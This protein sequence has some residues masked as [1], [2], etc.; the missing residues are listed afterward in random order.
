MGPCELRPKSSRSGN[1]SNE[2]PEVW[3]KGPDW[4]SKPKMW[5]A[6]VQTGPSKETEAEAKLAKEVVSV[7]VESGQPSPSPAM[8]WIVADHWYRIIGSKVSL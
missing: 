6:S 4:L 7:A 5:P 3:L 2:L 8:T 1:Q